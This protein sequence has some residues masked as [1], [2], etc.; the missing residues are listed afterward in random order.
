MRRADHLHLFK[1]LLYCVFLQSTVQNGIEKLEEA[2][3][4]VNE[5]SLFSSNE[6]LDELAT[7]DLK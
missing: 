2:H 6:E 4:L 1:A 5:L 3:R 7:T